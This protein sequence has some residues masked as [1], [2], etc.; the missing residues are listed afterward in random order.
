MPTKVYGIYGKTTVEINLPVGK[1]SLPLLF[2]RGCL[3]RK[4]YR[5]ASYITS[6]KAVQDMIEDSPYFG[7]MIKLVK[8]YGYDKA[9]E[10]KVAAPKKT[11]TPK[12]VA[13]SEPEEEEPVLTEYPDVTTK[14]QLIAVVKA[15]GAKANILADEAK[16]KKFVANKG[17]SFPN[18]QF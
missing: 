8:V 12:P 10:E 3:D 17:L 6:N 7:R 4:N 9:P 14:E 15:Q 18:Y 11:A 5:P 1:A 16:I 2:E 13:K